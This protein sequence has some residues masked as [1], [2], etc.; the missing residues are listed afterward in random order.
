MKETGATVLITGGGSGIGTGLAVAFHARGA[1]VIIE[2]KTA[3][4]LA[5]VASKHPGMEVEVLDVA[6]A[7]QVTALAARIAG[8]HPTLNVVINN[9][10]IQTEIDFAGTTPI[11]PAILAREVDVNLKGLLF[12]S[13]APSADP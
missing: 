12:V 11:E 2:G 6:D 13:N 10:G 8:R 1:K 4:R 5:A 3:S 7:D 9:A